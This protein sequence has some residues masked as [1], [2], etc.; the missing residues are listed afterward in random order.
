MCSS[1]SS[2]AEGFSPKPGSRGSRA[3]GFCWPHSVPWAAWCASLCQRGLAPGEPLWC[4]HTHTERFRLSSVYCPIFCCSLCGSISCGPQMDAKGSWLGWGDRRGCR[5]LAGGQGSR[6]QG[7]GKHR[8]LLGVFGGVERVPMMWPSWDVQPWYT[9]GAAF[10]QYRRA[11]PHQQE[12]GQGEV[13]LP[14]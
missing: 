1:I 6:S 11:L 12:N 13:S 10:S 9:T 14:L 2:Q 4:S 5:G 8:M 3:G 7:W